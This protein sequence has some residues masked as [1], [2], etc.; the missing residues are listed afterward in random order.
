MLQFYRHATYYVHHSTGGKEEQHSLIHSEIIRG[1]I[2]D[3][4]VYMHNCVKILHKH[5]AWERYIIQHREIPH[6]VNH[7][8]GGMEGEHSYYILVFFLCILKLY[9]QCGDYVRLYDGLSS[10]HAF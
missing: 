4:F 7:Q 10:L 8:V 5:S 9:T 6:Y 3:Y 2:Y 1:Y